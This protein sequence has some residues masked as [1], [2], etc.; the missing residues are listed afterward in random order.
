MTSPTPLVV[1]DAHDESWMDIV[2]SGCHRPLV[3]WIQAQGLVPRDVYR[4]EIYLIDCPSAVVYA[5]ASNAA[6]HRYLD[7]GDIARREPYTMP[8]DSLPPTPWT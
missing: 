8:L 5:Y 7:G 3:E 6:G 2:R 1:I 4:L